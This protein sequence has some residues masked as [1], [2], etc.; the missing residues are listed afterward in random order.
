MGRALR[1][2]GRSLASDLSSGPSSRPLVGPQAWR[3]LRPAQK[4]GELRRGRAPSILRAFRSE[5]LTAPHFKSGLF[6]EVAARLGVKGGAEGGGEE[7]GEPRGKGGEAWAGRRPRIGWEPAL[8]FDATRCPRPRAGRDGTMSPP[9]A[10]RAPHLERRPTH[11]HLIGPPGPRPL[12]DWSGRS[13]KAPPISPPPSPSAGTLDGGVAPLLPSRSP[14]PGANAAELRPRGRCT[15]S[16]PSSRRE[17]SLGA[18]KRKKEEEGRGRAGCWGGAGGGRG[19]GW[20]ALA[21]GL[22]PARRE[23]ERGARAHVRVLARSIHPSSGRGTRARAPG[24]RRT[25]RPGEAGWS[26]GRGE[27]RADGARTA[28]GRGEVRRRRRRRD[29]KGGEG[30]MAAR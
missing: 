16:G 19:G 13:A 3:G 8:S 26:G 28:R 9:P 24:S 6:T 27:G 1:A 12:G 10:H 30:A 2:E 22:A 7:S 20:S 5:V 14:P 21:L 18:R 15:R 11:P 4:P 17:Q 25:P 23:G 29:K